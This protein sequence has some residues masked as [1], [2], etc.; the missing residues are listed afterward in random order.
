MNKKGLSP[1]QSTIILV[2]VSIII[3]IIVMSWGRAYV[4]KATAQAEQ[5]AANA[6][7][8]SL[9]ED[10]NTRLEKGEITKEQYDSIKEVLL[11]KGG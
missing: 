5:N 9:F 2:V 4:E 6:K 10:L 7:Q 1:L 8:E 11:T 3:G